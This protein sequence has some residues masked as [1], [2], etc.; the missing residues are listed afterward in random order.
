MGALPALVLLQQSLEQSLQRWGRR[1]RKHFNI[2]LEMF[3]N[4][5]LT[6]GLEFRKKYLLGPVEEKKIKK[7]LRTEKCH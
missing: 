4:L 5:Q 1:H 2:H 3:F 6:C 7:I